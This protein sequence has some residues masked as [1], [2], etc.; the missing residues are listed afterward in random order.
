MHALRIVS[1]AALVL[2]ASSLVPARAQAE[3]MVI[4]DSGQHQRPAQVDLL[5]SA[6]F[7][8]TTMWFGAA[9]WFSMP[10]LPN[11]FVPELNDALM[12]EVGAFA[13]YFTVDPVLASTY[14]YF[15]ISPMGGVRWQLYVTTQW[16]LFATLKLGARI[17]VAGNSAA[18]L[19]IE[20][21]GTV[22]AYYR[23]SENM[24]LRIE[25][26]NFGVVQV[27]IGLPML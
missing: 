26:G 9:G 22:G 18:S 15:A 1:L 8:G 2:C 14:S 23:M 27:G 6:W 25:T 24:F 10:L 16:A 11:G 21:A 5:G 12:L 3:E 20:P 4:Y 7:F 19:R 17:P 13:S